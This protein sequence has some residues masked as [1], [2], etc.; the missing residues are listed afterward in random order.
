MSPYFNRR[1][2]CCRQNLDALLNVPPH[3][4]VPVHMLLTPTMQTGLTVKGSHGR[5][6][7]GLIRLAV[8]SLF[9]IVS[10]YCPANLGCNSV[11]D[12]LQFRGSDRVRKLFSCGVVFLWHAL[13]GLLLTSSVIWNLIFNLEKVLELTPNNAAILFWGT[14]PWS[15]SW[16]WQEPYPDQSNVAC[17]EH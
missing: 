16:S 10:P 14:S 6:P 9:W 12:S 13:H 7:G 4:Q 2:N 8:W 1:S 17:L 5:P 11:E 3:F 15:C